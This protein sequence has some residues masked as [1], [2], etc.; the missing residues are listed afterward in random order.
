MKPITPDDDSRENHLHRCQ[1]I[2]ARLHPAFELE[3]DV[4]PAGR[5]SFPSWKDWADVEPMFLP[6]RNGI[7]C[8]SQ[9]GIAMIVIETGES[10]K[11]KK[12]KTHL[13]MGLEPSAG[14]PPTSYLLTPQYLSSLVGFDVLHPSSPEVALSCTAWNLRHGECNSYRRMGLAK[15][16]TSLPGVDFMR[17]GREVRNGPRTKMDDDPSHHHEAILLN[18]AWPGGP[19]LVEVELFSHQAFVGLRFKYADGSA[20]SVGK[21][22]NDRPKTSVRLNQGED[23]LSVEVRSGW[24]IDAA[25]VRVGRGS[26]SRDTSFVG[27]HGG[28]RRSLRPASE[29][30]EIVGFVASSGSWMDS[31]GVLV[32][33]RRR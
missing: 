9:A 2:R 28:G 29:E 1:A 16:L 21:V 26:Q 31:L 11:E 6:M 12:Y 3:G 8:N 30:E 18:S 32:A 24:W 5:A 17:F 19:P 4:Q 10:G 14:P 23:L 25:S 22:G 20:Q 13:E 33:D 15:P 27:G 7:R